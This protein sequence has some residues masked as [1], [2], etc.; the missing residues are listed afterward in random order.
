MVSVSLYADT[1]T[2]LKAYSNATKL[3][4]SELIRRALELEQLL[5]GEDHTWLE[6][7]AKARKASRAQVL[8]NVLRAAARLQR[9]D[10]KAFA[11][12]VNVI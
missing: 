2:W 9:A 8:L 10:A 12:F 1:V 3:S 5:S 6:A 7:A 11:R 4:R